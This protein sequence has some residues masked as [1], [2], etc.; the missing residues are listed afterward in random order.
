MNTPTVTAVIATYRRGEYLC[1]AIGS[2]LAQTRVDLEVLVSDSA[3]D[4]TE[5][6][7]RR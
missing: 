7:G 4:R 6:R 5:R 3:D 1:V 2:A